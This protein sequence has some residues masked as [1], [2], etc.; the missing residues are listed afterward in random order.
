MRSKQAFR[1]MLAN[2]FLQIAVLAVGF[3]LPRFF[4]ET[5]GD[6]ISGMMVTASQFLMCLSLAEAGIGTASVV[7]LYKPL[8][9]KDKKQMNLVLSATNRFYKRSGLIFGALLLAL[10]VIFPFVISEQIEPTLI[11][12]VLFVMGATTFIDYFFLG[13]YRVLLQADQKVY[14][15]SLVEMGGTL[16][17]LGISI[18]LIQNNANVVLVRLVATLIFLLRFFIIRSF[19]RKQYPQ[20]SFREKADFQLITQ[21]GAAL[22]HQVAGVIVSNTDMVI[23]AVFMGSRSLLEANVY[24][25]YN[26]AVNAIN[27]LL[28]TGINAF[29]AGFGEVF[30]KK[31]SK[32]LKRTYLQYEYLFFIVLFTVCACMWPLIL[33]FVGVYAIRAPQGVENY[34]RPVA[35]MLFVLVVFL[36][37]V[38]IPS[39]TMVCAAGHFEETK[40]QAILETV[41]NLVVSLALVHWLGL[42][43]VLLGTVAS[44]AYRTLAIV[45]YNGKHLVKGTL[46]T[47][48]KRLLRNMVLLVGIIIVSMK[49]IPQSMQNF[50]EWF[51]YALAVGSVSLLLFCILNYAFEPQEFRE[52][53]LRVRNILG[54]KFKKS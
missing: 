49:V 53:W 39:L 11:R 2:I 20:V 8:A 38:R 54:D 21:R 45:I 18:T 35:G 31:E 14:V 19:V 30:S 43:G 10:V 3:I 28:S 36:Q 15:L 1:N 29:M 51:L 13:K 22:I 41:I 34:I 12:A 9:D 7:A 16:L 4:L 47:T 40:K 46:Y 37:N 50:V 25:T 52:V 26:L 6:D 23:L 5:Y 24:A 48:G 32:T 17:N 27:T 42:T 33:P 44:F